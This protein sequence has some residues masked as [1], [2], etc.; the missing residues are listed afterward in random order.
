MVVLAADKNESIIS[1]YRAESDRI[2]VR[3]RLLD[4]GS[5]FCSLFFDYKKGIQ[6]DA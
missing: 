5:S 3:G 1:L 2:V 6:H 4:N